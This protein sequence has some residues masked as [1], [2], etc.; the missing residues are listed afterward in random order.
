MSGRRQALF[1]L[2]SVVVLGVL[3]YFLR[4]ILLPFVAGMAVAYFLDPLTD[5]LEV[6]CNRYACFPV[7]RI[8]KTAKS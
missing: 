1:W 2:A 4:G 7:E 6:L 3:V 5:K 8:E